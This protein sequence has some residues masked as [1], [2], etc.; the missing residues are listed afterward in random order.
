MPLIKMENG[1]RKASEELSPEVDLK[2]VKHDEDSEVEKKP[3]QNSHVVAYP[4]KVL[5]LSMARL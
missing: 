2:R 5:P 3:P 1:K 4:L